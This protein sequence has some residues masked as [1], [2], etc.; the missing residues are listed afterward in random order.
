MATNITNWVKKV[1]PHV[2]KCPD[3]VIEEYVIDTLRDFC[4]FTRLWDDNELT[5][6]DIVDGTHTYALTSASGDIVSIDHA[7]VEDVPIRPISLDEL[8]KPRVY[9]MIWA[10]AYWRTLE[11]PRASMYITGMSD[12]IRLVYTPSEDITGGLA[13]WVCLKP[14]ETAT[15]VEDFLWKEF[16][17]VITEGTIARLLGIRTKPW[18]N[19]QESLLRQELYEAGRY[20]A[21]NL[22]QTGRTRLEVKATPAFFA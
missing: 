14:L 11:A 2:P 17:D 5:A 3:P 4:H 19:L 9:S 20:T 18:Y 10:S 15:T 16:K 21:F 8:N 22:K 7:E 12:N 13:V 1:A 6:I